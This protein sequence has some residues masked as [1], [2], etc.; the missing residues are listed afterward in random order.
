M[1][2]KEICIECDLPRR[3]RNTNV[4][5]EDCIRCLTDN[6]YV[7]CTECSAWL[8]KST[9]RYTEHCVCDACICHIR[10]ALRDVPMRTE[11]YI[12]QIIATADL[13]VWERMA[14]YDALYRLDRIR[15]PKEGEVR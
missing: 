8:S 5:H 11:A 12:R 14:L 7:Q 13:N 10:Q 2:R 1:H 9:L 4:E 3:S 6:G 15:D